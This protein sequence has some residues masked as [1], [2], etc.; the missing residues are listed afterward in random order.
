[1]VLPNVFED[2]T[3]LYGLR[4]SPDL[5]QVKEKAGKCFY[6]ESGSYD[7]LTRGFS[8]NFKKVLRQVRNRLAK[9][10][11]V[12][13]VTVREGADLAAAFRELL[14][15][16]ASGWK[17]RDGVAM[18]SQEQPFYARLAENF[19]ARGRCEITLLKVEG[20]SVAG[21]LSLFAGD[22]VYP[23]RI[24]WEESFSHFRPGVALLNE[25][26][27][28]YADDPQIQRIN[29]LSEAAW[30]ERWQPLSMDVFHV[31][32]FNR[33]LR[34]RVLYSLARAKLPKTI[35]RKWVKPVRKRIQAFV[36]RRRA[37]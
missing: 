16:E 29:L 24:G 21:L 6:L 12:E 2:A 18:R 34:G 11:H 9:L 3:V 8:R 5:P 31:Y 25:V 10:E 13:F 7:E 1:M 27:R 4:S 17:G 14:E 19:A 20:R 23:T 35:Y 36:R 37:D 33:S 15:L 26:I 22:T 30:A 28:R 32:L